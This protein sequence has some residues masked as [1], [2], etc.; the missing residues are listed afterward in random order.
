VSG[1]AGD[2]RSFLS[3][4]DPAAAADFLALGAER[5]RRAGS[6]VL[7]EGDVSDSV[8]LVR[9]GRVKVLATTSDGRELV[10]GIRG[11]GEL[12]G[13]LSA[14]ADDGRARSASVVAID[15]V[16]VLTVSGAA[17]RA[18]VLDHPVIALDLVRTLVNRLREA[19][20]QRV[21]FGSLDVAHRVAR[22][23]VDLAGQEDAP[24]EG[25]VGIGLPLSQEEL[26]GMVSTSRETIARALQGLRRRDL[27]ATGRRSITV[28]DVERLRAYAES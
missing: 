22:L 4:L 2:H 8:L 14:I 10:L 12:L 3:R 5:A 7:I 27:V 11:P 23:L 13:E 16:R 1:A 25:P 19:D 26:A 17:F 20:R 9:A 15:D 18:F 6:T 21:E 28:L 24:A